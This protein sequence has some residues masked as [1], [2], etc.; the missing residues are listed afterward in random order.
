MA[1]Y[2]PN[3]VQMFVNPCKENNQQGTVEECAIFHTA[4]VEGS[5]DQTICC[6]VTGVGSLVWR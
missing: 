5:P 1:S 4:F 6:D 3:A 2:A